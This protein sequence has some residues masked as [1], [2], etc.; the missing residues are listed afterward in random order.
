[1]AESI[2]VSIS[3]TSFSHLASSIRALLPAFGYCGRDSRLP[4]GGKLRNLCHTASINFLTELVATFYKD[5]NQSLRDKWYETATASSESEASAPLQALADDLMDED[6]ARELTVQ[7]ASPTEN[8]SSAECFNK[9]IIGVLER[10]TLLSPDRAPVRQ[11]IT[12]SLS[13]TIYHITAIELQT[14]EDNSISDRPQYIVTHYL[15][16][17]VK[18]CK[19]TK[20]SYRSFGVEIVSSLLHPSSSLKLDAVL[21]ANEVYETDKLLYI[22]IRRCNDVAPTVRLRGLSSIYDIMLSLSHESPRR[23]QVTILKYALGYQDQSNKSQPPTRSR[24]SLLPSENHSSNDEH[25]LPPV[26]NYVNLLEIIRDR[27]QD[28]KPMVRAKAIQAYSLALSMTWPRNISSYAGCI[29]SQDDV[30][31]LLTEDDIDIFIHACN[32]SSS[33]TIRKQGLQG[34]TQLMQARPSDVLL[35]DAWIGS[36][37]PLVADAE[38]SIVQKLATVAYELIFETLADWIKNKRESSRKTILLWNL[39]VKIGSV[40]REGLLRSCVAVMI[41]QGL[42]ATNSMK[43]WF[44]S[45]WNACSYGEQTTASGASSI[46]NHGLHLEDPDMISKTGWILLEALINHPIPNSNHTTTHYLEDVNFSDTIVNYYRINHVSRQQAGGCDDEDVVRILKILDQLSFSLNEQQVHYLE[47]E[48]ERILFAFKNIQPQLLSAAIALRSSL[49]TDRDQLMSWC[50]PLLYRIWLILHAVIWEEANPQ[51]DVPI[52]MK[53]VA[54][55]LSSSHW[56]QSIVRTEQAK[57]SAMTTA[58]YLLGEIIMIGF[59]SDEDE[60][61]FYM[62]RSITSYSISKSNEIAVKV[63]I[64][65]AMVQLLQLAMGH[66]YPSASNGTIANDIRAYAFVTM[67][68]LCLRSQRQARDHI[69]IYLREINLSTHE[70]ATAEGAEESASFMVRNNALL[71]LSDFCI[72]YTNLIERHIDSIAACLQDPCLIIR[73][74]CLILLSSLILQDYIKF[75]TQI[76]FRFLCCL[77]DENLEFHELAKVIIH[78]IIQ[79]KY[80]DFLSLKFSEAIV[81]FNECYDHAVLQATNHSMHQLA[82]ADHSSS[83]SAMQSQTSDYED[84]ISY[85]I[86][87]ANNTSKRM[88][89]YN[90]IME[91]LSEEQRIQVTA[92][93]VQ[94]ILASAADRNHHPQ[95][96][97]SESE[98]QVIND[99]LQILQSPLLKVSRKQSADVDTD[100]AAEEEEISTAAAA[101]GTG[102]ANKD[103]MIARAKIRVLKVLSKQHMIN[104]ILPVAMSLKHMLEAQHSSLQGPLMEYLLYLISQ[105][106]AEVS[107]A[108]NADPILKLELEYDLKNYEKNKERNQRLLE[109]EQQQLAVERTRAQE[110]SEK[111]TVVKVRLSVGEDQQQRRVSISKGESAIRYDCIL[112]LMICL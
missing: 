11:A 45:I 6:E 54:A 40:R 52:S 62:P 99:C 12:L 44:K 23:L 18:L 33:I 19:S 32:D 63:M 109:A 9:C 21:W 89:I 55:S 30:T 79:A 93:I 35:Q 78:Q 48:M 61:S 96:V 94:D 1:L 70:A 8:L 58:L 13:Q 15:H 112:L 82:M 60:N 95:T 88:L 77:L 104:H 3:L 5:E 7:P 75:K 24:V 49:S 17:L 10:M 65:E 20:I 53:A 103:S 43:T 100:A 29:G 51:I 80:P 34:L 90:F 102:G 111:K 28:S 4:E 27:T 42:I 16:F 46:T 39:C 50:Q 41:K 108:L 31:M 86:A 22:L 83:A 25:P 87:G 85:H 101:A 38:S 92:K 105:H 71:I 98:S 97:L 14:E 84:R 69:N 110:L 47:A 2:L 36:A 57:V 72:R 91:G 74:H 107:E 81:L 67:G 106:K 66:H 76:L 64:P 26:S 56:L 59:S 37:L 73:R 68:K